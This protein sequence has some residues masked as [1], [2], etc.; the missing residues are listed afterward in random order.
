[1]RTLRVTL[2]F[3]ENRYENEISKLLQKIGYYHTKIISAGFVQ[4]KKYCQQFDGD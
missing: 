4:L 1:M 2:K 3:G